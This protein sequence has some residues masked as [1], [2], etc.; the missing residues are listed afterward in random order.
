MAAPVH[1]FQMRQFG[2]LLRRIGQSLDSA[3]L[4]LQGSEGYVERRE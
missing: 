2:R 1:G 4:G 3:G